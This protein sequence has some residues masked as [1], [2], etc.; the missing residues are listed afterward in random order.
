MDRADVSEY[1]GERYGAYLD[2]VSRTAADSV[3]NL[4]SVI[5]DALR[6]LG[7][8]AADIPTAV[9]A[10]EDEDDDLKL[11]ASYRLME[12][13]VRDMGPQFMDISTAGDSFKLSQ[14]KAAATEELNRLREEVLDRFGTLG[15]VATGDGD[16]FASIDVNN[17][18][19]AWSE[20]A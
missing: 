18:T 10:T 4:K 12:Q 1:L 17:L 9:S 5:D 11:Q 6:A 14:L 16:V 7:Y 13:V 2:A 19:D 20:V 15:V 8:A 3:G